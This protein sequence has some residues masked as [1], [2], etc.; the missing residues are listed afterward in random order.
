MSVNTYIRKTKL[1]NSDYTKI[2]TMPY[3]DQIEIF[4]TRSLNKYKLLNTKD[5]PKIKWMISKENI[6]QE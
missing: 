5:T 4:K 1:N 6:I 3:K 2:A